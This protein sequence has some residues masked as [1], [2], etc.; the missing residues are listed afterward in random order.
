MKVAWMV[1]LALATAP[2]GAEGKKSAEDEKA[3]QQ[4]ERS[5]RQT[6]NRSAKAI[7]GCTERYLNA[8]PK[9]EGQ[10]RVDVKVKKDG[11]ASRPVV[12]TKLPQARTLRLCLEAVAKGWR[13]QRP[14]EETPI[15]ITIPVAKGAKFK[16]SPP[17]KKTKKPHAAPKKEGF[18]RLSSDTFSPGFG[19]PPAKESK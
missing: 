19:A 8:Q 9:A 10:V 6:F 11:W 12:Q 7:N 1:S 4:A 2:G 13:F 18:L 5:I 17:G 15:G 16:L 3:K 14:R